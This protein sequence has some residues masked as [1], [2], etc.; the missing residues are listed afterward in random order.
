[1]AFEK[2]TTKSR[3]LSLDEL[4][5]SKQS[6]NLEPARTGEAAAK[7][8]LPE[9]DHSEMYC[10]LFCLA[11]THLLQDLLED[12]EF[13]TAL[14]CP[15]VDANLEL[16]SGPL[17]L[18]FWETYS[19]QFIVPKVERILTQ[20][21]RSYSRYK[22]LDKKALYLNI[23]GD[24]LANYCRRFQQPVAME[25][26]QPGNIYSTF[27]R[28]GALSAHRTI[29][30]AQLGAEYKAR[31]IQAASDSS[32][33]FLLNLY[34]HL[35]FHDIKLSDLCKMVRRQAEDLDDVF[36]FDEAGKPVKNFDQRA[37]SLGSRLVFSPL[38]TNLEASHL[39]RTFK[40]YFKKLPS[41]F[42][43][44]SCQHGRLDESVRF[45]IKKKIS[46]LLGG[47]KVENF[48]IEFD[49]TLQLPPAAAGLTLQDKLNHLMLQTNTSCDSIVPLAFDIEG[50]DPEKTL[51]RS[52]RLAVDLWQP[53][54]P[55][56]ILRDHYM[57]HIR[58]IAGPAPADSAHILILEY[59]TDFSV[60]QDLLCKDIKTELLDGDKF[61]YYKLKS[62]IIKQF[63]AENLYLP[64]LRVDNRE[65]HST[66]WFSPSHGY[67]F[68]LLQGLDKIK[69]FIYERCTD[70]F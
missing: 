29:Y 66:S 36:V 28:L 16:L 32:T 40:F 2:Q 42:F 57:Q 5:L 68:N 15:S 63:N 17:G 69:Y 44:L 24:I 9:G 13:K 53:K 59:P 23:I 37:S 46:A 67:T 27:T 49:K 34:S 19:S 35:G 56:D 18:K 11:G 43:H 1:M 26:E 60:N 55:E 10:L 22:N 64:I 65:E 54:A 45:Y 33:D 8:Q 41:V 58:Q 14:K 61:V 38:V 12:E 4:G 70:N 62:V 47:L 31:V 7:L 52:P 48:S 20:Y 51:Y 6:E 25:T 3:H 30:L 39:V 21:Q 50:L